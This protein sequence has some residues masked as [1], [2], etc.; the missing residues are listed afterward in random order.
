MKKIT[1]I[2]KAVK[3]GTQEELNLSYNFYWAYW[4]SRERKNKYLNINTHIWSKDIDAVF[5]DLQRYGIKTF[6]VSDNSTGLMGTLA[7]FCERGCKVTG[8]VKVNGLK[9]FRNDGF[10]VENAIKLQMPR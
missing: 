3:N 7:E 5:S 1:E 9:S 2:E 10:E 4:E 6:T 8:M